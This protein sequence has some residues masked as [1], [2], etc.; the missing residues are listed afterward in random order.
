MFNHKVIGN[1]WK[2]TN[3]LKKETNF[4]IIKANE[5]IAAICP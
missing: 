4:L 3:N 1:K 2:E 5:A